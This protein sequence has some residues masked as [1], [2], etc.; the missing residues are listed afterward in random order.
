V[1]EPDEPGR[2]GRAAAAAQ[3]D[4]YGPELAGRWVEV[5]HELQAVGPV[6][7]SELYGGYYVLTRYADVCAAARDDDTFSSFH[8]TYGVRGGEQ[9]IVIANNPMHNGFIELD[10][11][12]YQHYRRLVAPWFAPTA[13]Q[14][15]HP[16]MVALASAAVDRVIERGAFDIVIDFAKPISAAVTL[17]LMGMDVD[18]WAI[19]SDAFHQMVY[20]E[21]A[22][23]EYAHIIE[24]HGWILQ[25]LRDTVT[26]RRRHPRGDLVSTL[27]T[28][29]LEPGRVLTDQ[30]VVDTLY[31]FLG[32][33]L[34]TTMS[35]VSHALLWLGEHPEDR[36]R[37]VEDRGLVPSACEEFLRYSTPTQGL[38]RT[39]TKPCVVA[40]HPFEP[41]DRVLL[42]WAAANVD[43]EVFESPDT[44]IMDRTPNPHTAW[45]V[46]GHR[47]IGAN[48]ARAEFAIMLGEILDR[49]PEYEIIRDRVEVFPRIGLTNGYISIPATFPPGRRRDV[50]SA[51]AERM[52]PREEGNG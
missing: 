50:R 21:R 2:R 19:Y 32:G 24:Q 37:L 3:F 4:L 41:G 28:A 13:V 49:I 6:V 20:K 9:G 12:E 18:E 47:C 45:G 52:W 23:P 27:C 42:A 30:E 7:H 48:L 39:V 31:L 16:E 29:E 34:N 17:A 38:A 26:D 35:L 1:I 14:A 36:R 43:D 15:L 40:G 33:G 5:W 8:D 25:R 11:P 22:A 10:P 51:M 46:G 44:V